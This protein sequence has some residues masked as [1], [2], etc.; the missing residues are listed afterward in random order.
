VK[1]TN[2]DSWKLFTKKLFTLADADPGYYA[3][4]YAHLPAKQKQRIA[5]GWCAFYNLAVAAEASEYRSTA[6]WQHLRAAYPT[7]KRN[8]ERRH[9]RGAA[10]LR[11]LDNWQAQHP[12]PETMM[13]SIR[14]RTYMEVREQAMPLL[15]CGDYFKWKFC[16][17]NEVLFNNTVDMRGSGKYSPTVPKRAAAMLFPDN[18]IDEAYL[19]IVRYARLKGVRTLTNPHREFDIQDAETVCCVYKQYQK[20]D[21]VYGLRS[22]KAFTRLR[23]SECKTAKAMVDALLSVSPYS[24]KELET[25][26]KEHAK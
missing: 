14:G 24:P 7:A 21:Y 1:P 2:P 13:L 5:V 26:F 16:D 6:F 3:I 9:F 17:L 10:G 12:E 20:G 18:T 23:S 25:I 19:E 8:S 22:A 11:A 4:Q 15:L